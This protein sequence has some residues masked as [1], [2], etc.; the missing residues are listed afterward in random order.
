MKAEQLAL[1]A[2][3]AVVAKTLRNHTKRASRLKRRAKALTDTDLLE[4][5]RMRGSAH[6]VAA[7]AAE[8]EQNPDGMN[9]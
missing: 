2:Q 8:D 5:L 9:P 6:A 7:D 1:R 4:L 3:K